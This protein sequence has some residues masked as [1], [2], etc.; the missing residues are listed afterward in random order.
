MLAEELQ[1]QSNELRKG[2]LAAPLCW[3]KV[4]ILGIG[5]GGN[6][7]ASFPFLN[8]LL[9]V[10]ACFGYECV[11]PRN[12]STTIPAFISAALEDYVALAVLVIPATHKIC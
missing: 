8:T 2:G 10:I 3:Y 5:P 12:V 11:P 6:K 4:V 9:L 1:C 7:S